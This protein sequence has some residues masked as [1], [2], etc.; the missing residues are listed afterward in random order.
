ME[1]LVPIIIQA[2]SGMVGGGVV[3]AL[4]KQAAI[5]I[6][7]RLLAGAVGGVGG[8]LALDQLLP[9]LMG[10]G[11]EGAMGPLVTQIV[12][13]LVGGGALTGIAGALLGGKKA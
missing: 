8:G 13:G 3:G 10:A 7:P 5:A 11:A 9:M 12:G 2:I 4:V 1:A 6:V